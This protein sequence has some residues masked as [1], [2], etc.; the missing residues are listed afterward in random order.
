MNSRNLILWRHADAEYLNSVEALDNDRVL[1]ANGKVQA[2]KMAGWLKQHLPKDTLILSSPAVRA[3]QTVAALRRDY[4]S[5]H[6]LNPEAGLKDILVV[7][8]E[9]DATNVLLVGHQPWLGQLVS[10]L[11]DPSNKPANGLKITSIKK[12]AVWWFKQTKLKLQEPSH[13]QSYKLV[14]VQHPDFI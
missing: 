3:E 14:T 2:K 12:G 10:H 11:T 13:S 6:A 8:Q 7:L 9:I 1:S 4:Q 5:V